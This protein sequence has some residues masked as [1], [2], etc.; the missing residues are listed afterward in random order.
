[1][2]PAFITSVCTVIS[3]LPSTGVA[4]SRTEL[5]LS[6]QTRDFTTSSSHAGGASGWVWITLGA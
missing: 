5:D 6:P 3:R 2:T 1:V 4:G